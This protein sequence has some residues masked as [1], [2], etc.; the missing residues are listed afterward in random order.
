MIYERVRV[1]MNIFESPAGLFPLAIIVLSSKGSIAV[2]EYHL[3]G[4]INEKDS[5][6]VCAESS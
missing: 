5:I 6:T 2:A 4:K 1:M 3:R